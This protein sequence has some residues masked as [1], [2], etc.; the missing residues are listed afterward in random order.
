M[1]DLEAGEPVP[2]PFRL[3]DL[4]GVEPFPLDRQPDHPQPAPAPAKRFC[5][6]RAVKKVCF[7]TPDDVELARLI[8]VY[9]VIERYRFGERASMN[10]LLLRL[11]RS[12]WNA[13]VGQNRDWL[14]HVK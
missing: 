2:K 1:V 7:E 12:G 3:S 4:A 10:D 9:H 8:E 6:A 14:H 13:E 11:L 5:A